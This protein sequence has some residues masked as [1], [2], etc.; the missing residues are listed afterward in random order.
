MT[1]IEGVATSITAFLGRAVDGPINEATPITSYAD[2]QRIFGGLKY[3]FPLSYAVRDFFMNGGAQAVIVRLQGRELTL[4][5]SDY[6]GSRSNREGIFALEKTSIFNLLCI[7]DDSRLDVRS[8]ANIY[9][10]Y[11][12]ALPYC[13]E[14]RAMLI[15]DAPLEWTTPQG[16]AGLVDGPRSKLES[17]IGLAGED[18]PNAIL[19]YPRIRQADPDRNGQIDS[20]VPCGIMAGIIARTDEL[21]G[22]WKAPAG[23]GASLVGI[24]SLSVLLNDVQTGILNK[25]GINCLRNFP[26]LGNVVW[27]ARTLD[28]DDQNASPWKF[29]PVR[30]T[31]LYIEESVD[32]GTQWAVFEPNDEQLWEKLRLDVGAFMDNLFRQGA[33]QG[34][35][36]RDAYFV[37]CDQATTT[38]PD[39]SGGIV[40]IL[41]GFAPL[42]AWRIRS[43]ET[44]A[45]GWPSRSLVIA[46]PINNFCIPL[47]SIHHRRITSLFVRLC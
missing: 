14:R 30:R 20:F 34:Q 4:S 36:P 6:L 21:R 1:T 37:K 46:V 10:V 2:F 31:A 16:V 41:V 26:A 29:F 18:A 7:P 27:G 13:R 12:T 3:E 45:E 5:T 40:N 11:R 17:D 35:A 42:R 39:V 38:P 22:V 9:E 23:I 24:H 33:F 8:S 44:L 15:V 47:R 32:R 43:V 28:G 19:I 25:V